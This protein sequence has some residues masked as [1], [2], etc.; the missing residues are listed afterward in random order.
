ML[1]HFRVEKT[2]LRQTDT[3]CEYRY[4]ITNITDQDA[5]L[6]EYEVFSADTLEEMGLDGRDCMLFRTGRHKNDMPAA[7]RFGLMDECMQD[8]LG[9]MTESGDKEDAEPWNVESIWVAKLSN[10]YAGV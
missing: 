8:A 1:P 3:L 6:D 9:G 5:Y 4:A 7:A 2:I 10:K